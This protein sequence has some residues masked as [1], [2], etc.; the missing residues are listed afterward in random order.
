MSFAAPERFIVAFEAGLIG[1]LYGLAAIDA[2]LDEPAYPASTARSRVIAS[3]AVASL[4]TFALQIVL[5][6]HQEKLPHHGTRK[7]KRQIL[8]TSVTIDAAD[9]PGRREGVPERRPTSRLWEGV[10][11]GRRFYRLWSRI[12]LDGLWPFAESKTQ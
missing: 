3:G 6:G 10:G 7:L 4:A 11:F 9:K 5:R 2:I 1:G 8:M 12:S